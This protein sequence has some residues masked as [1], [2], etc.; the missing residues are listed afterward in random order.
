[1]GWSATQRRKRKCGGVWH[2]S[3]WS[4]YSLFLCLGLLLLILAA[5]SLHPRHLRHRNPTPFQ[6]D[7]GLLYQNTTLKVQN[8]HIQQLRSAEIARLL[9]GGLSL[10]LS[11]VS[12]EVLNVKDSSGKTSR[13]DSHGNVPNKAIKDSHSPQMGTLTD[14]PNSIRK[15]PRSEDPMFLVSGGTINVNRVQVAS[16]LHK[17]LAEKMLK[18]MCGGGQDDTVGGGDGVELV[19]LIL[20]DLTGPERRQAMRDTWLSPYTHPASPVRHFFLIGRNA[21]WDDLDHVARTREEMETHLD[22]VQVNGSDSY[23][24]LTTKVLTGLSLLATWCQGARHVLK[25]DHDVW[26]NVPSLRAALNATPITPPTGVEG[27]CTSSQRPIRRPRSKY[28]IPESLFPYKAY[29]RFC[30]GPGYVTTPRV[31]GQIV[32]VSLSVPFFP[33]EDVFLGMCLQRLGLGVRHNRG[34]AIGKAVK[35]RQAVCPELCR[36]HGRSVIVRHGFTPEELRAIWRAGECLELEG[37]PCG[38]ET[39]S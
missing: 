37:L 25:T 20:S 13:R 1:M 12:A 21:S 8:N 36:Y 4:M 31:A 11:N 7:A 33:L 29:P 26:V 16:L 30:N 10:H 39:S 38:N 3:A 24:H 14:V 19:V 34:F 32:A 9:R 22:L 15:H 2:L 18:R 17:A 28:Y 27:Y 23:A 35:S 5:L 6:L